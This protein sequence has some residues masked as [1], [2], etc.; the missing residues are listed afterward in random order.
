MAV[1]FDIFFLAGLFLLLGFSADLTVKNIKKI[2]SF[3]ELRVF[4]FGVILGIITTLPELSV[5]INAAINRVTVL[6]V[7]NVF[8][9]IV[10]ILGLITGLNLVLNRKIATKGVL[11]S[12]F[13]SA[14]VMLAAF[15]LGIDGRYGVG[16]GL[17]IIFLYL[18]LLVYLYKANHHNH[19]KR[20]IVLEKGK[21]AQALFLSLV[22]IIL[23]ILFSNWIVEV[24]VDLLSRA[25][26]SKIIIGASYFSLGTNLPEIIIAITSW[27][28]KSPE[29]SLSHLISSAFTNVAILGFLAV[30]TPIEFSR[31]V[32]FYL[33][34]AFLF[35][36]LGAFTYFC[37]SQKKLDKREG[38]FLLA[39]YFL[40]LTASFF[41]LE[42][43]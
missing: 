30:M 42:F 9:G 12:L 1:F 36:I 17:V 40:F 23:V 4:I 43:F 15:L 8:G 41:V 29:L 11:E 5:G 19:G 10:V 35:L 27:K 2:A 37:F 14:G 16:D 7:G 25:N 32:A 38:Y 3:L 13:P 39:I 34:G 22:G 24:T 18:F 33:L 6:S 20:T 21:F 31:G 28:R 26:L